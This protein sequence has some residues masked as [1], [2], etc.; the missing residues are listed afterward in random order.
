VAAYDAAIFVWQSEKWSFG[1]HVRS[2][3]G[4]RCNVI[5][6]NSPISTPT[7]KKNHQCTLVLKQH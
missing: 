3:M 5:E 6:T 7:G 4:W 1:V 2:K